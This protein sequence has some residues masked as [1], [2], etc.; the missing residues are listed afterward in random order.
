MSPRRLLRR[1]RAEA[2]ELGH[3]IEQV[4]GVF[5]LWV[6][7]QGFGLCDFQQLTIAHDADAV[8]HL[9]DHRQVV[10]DEQ[11]GQVQLALQVFQQVQHVRLNRHIQ[12]RCRLAAHQKARARCEADLARTISTKEESGQSNA[13]AWVSRS[14]DCATSKIESWV[15]RASVKRV[16][17]F[18]TNAPSGQ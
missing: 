18:H 12:R 9:A 5:V 2:C 10:A 15:A 7:E 17:S 8:A 1:L 11:N 13:A 6:C 4:R 3:Q 14:F 16:L